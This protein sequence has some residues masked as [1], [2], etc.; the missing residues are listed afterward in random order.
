L[1]DVVWHPLKARTNGKTKIALPGRELTIVRRRKMGNFEA[2]VKTHMGHSIKD[3][4]SD[5]S[6]FWHANFAPLILDWQ[7][8]LE[9]AL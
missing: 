9:N 2:E 6:M 5:A 4:T 1:G 7:I 3:H 8:S